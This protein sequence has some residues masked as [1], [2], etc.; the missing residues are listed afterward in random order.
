MRIKFFAICC[1]IAFSSLTRCD[2]QSIVGKWKGVSVQNY[3]SAEY[4]KQAGKSMEEKLAKDFGN[5]EISFNPDHTF[6]LRF[7]APQSTEVTVM[8]GTW[9]SSGNEV[10]STLEQKYNPKNMTTSSTFSITGNT[11]IMTAT[12]QPPSR[13]VKTIS[14]ST[15]M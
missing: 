10:R 13:I 3:Y 15:R 1:V 7:S 11:M 6:E 14:I 12:I 4:A 8:K 2:A 5:S 9:S